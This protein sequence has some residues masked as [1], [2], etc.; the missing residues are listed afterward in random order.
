MHISCVVEKIRYGIYFAYFEKL[1]TDSDLKM[2]AKFDCFGM[3]ERL[4]IDIFFL[5]KRFLSL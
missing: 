3:I 4:S 1:V 5:I 2:H